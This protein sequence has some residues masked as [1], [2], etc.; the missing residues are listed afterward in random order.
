MLE[1][2]ATLAALPILRSAAQGDGIGSAQTMY[3]VGASNIASAS[4]GVSFD[5]RPTAG[6]L[7]VFIRTGS[8]VGRVPLQF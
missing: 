5:G 1:Y 7:R 4:S 8:F 3:R 6:L 2:H